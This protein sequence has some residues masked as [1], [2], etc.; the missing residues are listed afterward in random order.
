METIENKERAICLER[1]MGGVGGMHKTA[2]SRSDLRKGIRFGMVHVGKREA[3]LL[4]YHGAH[5]MKY[6][7]NKTIGAHGRIRVAGLPS[8]F[9]QQE[10]RSSFQSET[11]MGVLGRRNGRSFAME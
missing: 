6:R 9:R 3:L 7:E 11:V 5:W 8:S 2:P 4:G 1:E 10:H